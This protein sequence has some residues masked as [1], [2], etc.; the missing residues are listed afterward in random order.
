MKLFV[1]QVFFCCCFFN[2]PTGSAVSSV[3]N[4]CLK[5]ELLMNDFEMR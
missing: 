4:N 1:V 5:G 2:D 3:K